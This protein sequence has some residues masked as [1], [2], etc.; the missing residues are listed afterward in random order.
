MSMDPALVE[1]NNSDAPNETNDPFSVKHH[2]QRDDENAKYSVTITRP[3]SLEELVRKL[4]ILK[5]EFSPQTLKNLEFQYEYDDNTP[6]LDFDCDKQFNWTESGK[7]FT[8]VCLNMLLESVYCLSF[9][10]CPLQTF[11]NVQLPNCDVLSFDQSSDCE[12]R[13][14]FTAPKLRCISFDYITYESEDIDKDL[15]NSLSSSPHLE[16]FS[17]Y[18]LRGLSSL[19]PL[20][21]PSLEDITLYR[22]ECLRSLKLYAPRM[23]QLNLRAAY[24]ISKVK[25]L[26][27]GKKEHK[28]LTHKLSGKPMNS[29]DLSKFELNMINVGIE[30]RDRITW[31]NEPRVKKIRWDPDDDGLFGLPSDSTSEEGDDPEEDDN[32]PLPLELITIDGLTE[33][34]KKNRARWIKDADENKD[35]VLM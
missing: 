27:R 26:V 30:K 13:L 7:K 9:E 23:K 34:E 29:K 2:P 4:S 28:N 12:D 11:L 14:T 19:G 31:A 8:N 15:T 22:A 35:C 33:K 25:L 1:S 32:E 21:M 17:S 3:V 16:T 10:C 24:D 5:H 20:Y 6:K 18:K